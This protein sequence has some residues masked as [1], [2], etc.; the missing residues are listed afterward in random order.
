MQMTF[1]PITTWP[2]KPTSFS[3]ASNFKSSYAQT[4]DLLDREL[5]HLG[6][7]NVVLQ[8]FFSE[9]DVRLDGQLRGDARP[10]RPGV[11]L[12]FDSKHGPLSY[13]CDTYSGWKDNLRAIALALEALRSV[14]RYG[15]TKRA[16][17]YRG[18]QALPGPSSSAEILDRKAAMDLLR[19]IIGV[20]ADLL[21]VIQ[22][23]RE[24]ERASHPDAG[25]NAED[26]KRVQQ[27]RSILGV[28]P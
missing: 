21:P 22:A 26:F 13:P 19:K 10:G 1:R 6:A 8:G 7:K 16:E 18:W 4:L 20:R 27:A 17:Q 5:R 3:R 25:G 14:D 15:V 24:A 12:A 2:G 11:I 9:S 23:L 28:K